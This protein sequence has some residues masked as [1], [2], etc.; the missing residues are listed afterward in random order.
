MKSHNGKIRENAKCSFITHVDVKWPT[1]TRS[2]Q[3]AAVIWL[4]SF[5]KIEK[6]AITAK[7]PFYDFIT[8][9]NIDA[10]ILDVRKPVFCKTLIQ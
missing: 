4:T 2:R 5:Y 1:N 7:W 9:H 6:N 8:F 3:K 10:K